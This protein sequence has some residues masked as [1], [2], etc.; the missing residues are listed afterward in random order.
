MWGKYFQKLK[1][2][3]VEK[4]NEREDDELIMKNYRNI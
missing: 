1:D 4:K 2:Y 3:G